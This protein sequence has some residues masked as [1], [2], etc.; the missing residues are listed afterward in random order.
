[1]IIDQHLD[2][3][4]IV[5]TWHERFGSTTLQRVIPAA[6]RCIDAARPIASDT[7][8]DT[9]DYQNYGGLAI[10]HRDSV[11][12]QKRTLDASVLTFEC[13]YGYATTSCVTLCY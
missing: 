4:V 6:Y 10:I 12:F 13:L 9:V 8:I 5:E 2:I 1:M 7:L 3:I 11:C